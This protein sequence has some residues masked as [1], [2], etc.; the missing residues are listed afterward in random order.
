[1]FAFV[2]SATSFAVL[3]L[4][5]QLW[6]ILVSMLLYGLGM[7]QMG[8]V[9]TNWIVGT[10]ADDVRGRATGVMFT[11]LFLG[12][13]LSRIITQP[14]IDLI[15]LYRTFGVLAAALALAAGAYFVLGRT[16]ISA[17]SAGAEE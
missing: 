8:P 5:H 10:A 4:A 16:G 7:G 12:Q 15:G 3:S 14:V 13:F 17:P 11:A 6:L 9:V 1:T 2:V